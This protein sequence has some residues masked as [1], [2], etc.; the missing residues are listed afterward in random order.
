[1]DEISNAKEIISAH[2]V[3]TKEG[4]GVI[5]LNGK[6]VEVLHVEQAK[7]LLNRASAIADLE[8]EIK[9]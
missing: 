4:K 3:A 7:D 5:T 9:L 8:K 1:M 2:K 6:L